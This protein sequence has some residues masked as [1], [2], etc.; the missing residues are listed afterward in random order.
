MAECGGRIGR[1]MVDT[2][3]APTL[4]SG[5]PEDDNEPEH[6]PLWL[7]GL[8]L[9]FVLGSLAVVVIVEVSAFRGH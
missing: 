6:V 2:R 8:L 5:E 3:A 1:G 4:A 7:L 9:T